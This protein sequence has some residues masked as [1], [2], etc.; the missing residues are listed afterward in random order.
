MTHLEL[1]A[2]LHVRPGQLDGFKA[3]AAE[4]VR[5]ARE[6]D[7]GTLRFDWYLSEDGT[8][9]E[10]HETYESGEAFFAHAQH[11][12]AACAKLF[13]EYADGHRVAAFG[14]VP[15][16]LLAM[17]NTHGNGIEQYSFMQGLELEPSV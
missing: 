6:Q 5:C 12:M 15:P 14:E 11:I 1:R 17:A 3:Q 10:V 9:C 4:I 8:Q 2:Q 13:A 7:T 16:Q